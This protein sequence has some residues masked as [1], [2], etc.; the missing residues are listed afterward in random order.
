MITLD[1][2][3]NVM[4]NQMN[5]RYDLA[6]PTRNNLSIVGLEITPNTK[7]GQF[8]LKFNIGSKGNTVVD[9]YNEEGT[10]KLSRG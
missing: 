7:K 10:L 3:S 2:L 1:G 6:I 5:D 8:D 9:I 4:I